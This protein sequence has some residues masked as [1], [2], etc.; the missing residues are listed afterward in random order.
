MKRFIRALS[1]SL[2]FSFSLSFP[3]L[4]SSCVTLDA[5]QYVS[6]NN[7]KVTR[8]SPQL[9]YEMDVTL[10]NPNP[11]G[12]RVRELNMQVTVLGNT[13]NIISKDA[14]QIKPKAN[15]TMPLKGNTS[16]ANYSTFL[17]NGFMAILGGK[18]TIPIQVEGD[19]LV[20]KL[21]IRKRVHFSFTEQFDMAKIA[22]PKR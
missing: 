5:P 19:V 21:F 1:F 20:Q 3:F 4:F 6:T 18:T 16:S 17:K 9:D 11:A 2:A 8:I 14:V 10:Y 15:F 13:S 12:V 7:F 22:L